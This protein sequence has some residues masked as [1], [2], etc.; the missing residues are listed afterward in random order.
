MYSR[1]VMILLLLFCAEHE[2]R[3]S[4]DH[5]PGGVRPLRRLEVVGGVYLHLGELGYGTEARA[6]VGVRPVLHDGE[7]VRRHVLTVWEPRAMF[8]H[9]PL[10][11]LAVRQRLWLHRAGAGGRG[12]A[13][14]V[15]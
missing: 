10:P 15:K 12:R 11:R 7:Q 1:L 9:A 14:T 13:S 8:L 2:Q 3:A 5:L 6:A 4:I